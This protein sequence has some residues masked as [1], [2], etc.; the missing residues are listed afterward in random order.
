MKAIA[1]LFDIIPG[2]IYAIAIAALGAAAF[3]ESTLK[4]HY[5]A[6]AVLQKAN[7]TKLASAIETQKNEAAATLR[8]LNASVLA[9]QKTI[10]AAS[11]AQE[12]QDASNAQ[13]VAGLQQGLHDALA[14][15]GS[16]MCNPA[17]AGRGGGRGGAA[18]Q[19]AA[20]ADAGPAD[21]AQAGGVLQP[22]A[23]GLLER[24]M[25]E[26]DAVN[27]AYASCKVDAGVVRGGTDYTLPAGGKL[28]AP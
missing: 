23:R 10:D 24:L 28:P 13:V 8:T 21:G 9:Q 20:G 22:D 3:G 6:E 25:S 17:P 7:V 27:I 1:D 14:T 19:A 12:K 16:R 5:K 18:G 2:W 11:A 15:R 26:A 4:D